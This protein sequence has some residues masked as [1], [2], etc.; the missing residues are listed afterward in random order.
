[1]TNLPSKKI[2]HLHENHFE[3]I[4]LQFARERLNLSRKD[5]AK[6]VHASPSFITA[7]EKGRKRPSQELEVLLAS[8]LRVT[9]RY[10]YGQ[11]YGRWQLSDCH[12]RHRQ[13]V[14]K[15]EQ[16][17]LRSELYFYSR[18]IAALRRLVKLPS[19]NLPQITHYDL[20]S[21]EQIAGEVRRV[22]KISDSKPID[23][24]CRLVENAGIPIL[25]S[26]SDLVHIDAGSHYD[27]DPLIV[28]RRR[29]CGATRI[30][31]D[32]AHEVGELIFHSSAANTVAHERKINQF[33]GS[34]LMPAPG[35]SPHF[36]ARL[37]TLSHLWE[38]KRTWRVSLSAILQRALALE[39][40]THE[41]FV[42]WKRRF[43]ARGWTRVEPNEPQ[44]AGPDLL[45]RSFEVLVRQG[46]SLPHF[47]AQAGFSELGLGELLRENALGYLMTTV[48]PSIGSVR[49][50]SD[51]TQTELSLVK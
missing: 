10:F 48:V 50:P 24:L 4:K 41:I 38:L 32:V 20:R 17:R 34:L 46:T 18:V 37:L 45:R 33:V 11:V 13:A 26:S 29:N 22:W 47:A 35:F 5:L 15:A 14:T 30:I 40:I 9:T 43:A 23:Q 8:E 16:A 31:S 36:E 49:S 6:R 25:L 39:L 21:I 42:S 1:M 3:G 12:F 19:V 7:C 28:V 2:Y 51:L 44:L 27:P